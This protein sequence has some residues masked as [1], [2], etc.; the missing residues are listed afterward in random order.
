MS[1]KRIRDIPAVVFHVI[2][3]PLPSDRAG[4]VGPRKHVRRRTEQKVTPGIIHVI[5]SLP[6]E[7]RCS[8]AETNKK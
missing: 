2:E 5:I 4:Q 7:R 1:L 6:D 8:L 3:I